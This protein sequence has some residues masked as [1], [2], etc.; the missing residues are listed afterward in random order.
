[1]KTTGITDVSSFYEMWE[2]VV[3]VNGLCVRFGRAGT[4]F[5]RGMFLLLR[6]F[7]TITFFA[8]PA[9]FNTFVCTALWEIW[10]GILEDL[11]LMEIAGR[12]Q[13]LFVEVGADWDGNSH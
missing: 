3:A 4:A 12:R 11:R 6:V 5:L 2:A 7:T 1:M 10:K 8:V 13:Q 9:I